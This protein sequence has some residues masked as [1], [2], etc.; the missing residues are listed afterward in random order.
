MVL[1]KNTRL[2]HAFY[3][4]WVY[5]IRGQL[6]SAVIMLSNRDQRILDQ[7]SRHKVIHLL[8]Y[9]KSHQELSLS[10]YVA[11]LHIDTKIFQRNKQRR[12]RSVGTLCI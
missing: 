11:F 2:L 12:L 6:A 1:P 3:N 8:S 10:E 4:A 9:K 5:F 7:R